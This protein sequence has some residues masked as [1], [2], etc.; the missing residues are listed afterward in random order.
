[1][2][3]TDA[4]THTNVVLASIVYIITAGFLLF[5]TVMFAIYT[6]EISADNWIYKSFTDWY[7]QHVWIPIIRIA[8][9][10]VFVTLAYP[11]ILGLNQAPP[12]M[13]VLGAD[14]RFSTLINVLFAVTIIL[15][16]VPVIGSLHAL[17]LPAQGIAAVLLLVNWLLPIQ[18]HTQIRF[19]PDSTL[20]IT[21]LIMAIISHWLATHAAEFIGDRL[22]LWLNRKGFA[23]VVYQITLLI[24][25][26]P[27]ILM[28]SLFI[29][30]QLT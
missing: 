19:F 13:S 25:Q 12:I 30:K 11:T 28:Y 26:A 21:I 24:F 27:I 7:L 8:A 18:H 15:P 14:N 23:A 10:V 17:V 29:G 9:I 3:L 5:I 1:M 4:L 22:D 6:E 20:S 2:T 16:L